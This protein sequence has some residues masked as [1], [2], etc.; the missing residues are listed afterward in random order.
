M[1]QTQQRIKR[2]PETEEAEMKF[3]DTESGKNQEPCD[4]YQGLRAKTQRKGQG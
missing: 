3:K 1:K 2:N 4:P